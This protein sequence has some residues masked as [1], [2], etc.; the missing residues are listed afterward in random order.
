MCRM[1]FQKVWIN[2]I[3]LRTD[4]IGHLIHWK[5]DEIPCFCSCCI[6]RM[7]WGLYIC[8]YLCYDYHHDLF[9][10]E[11]PRNELIRMKIKGNFTSCRYRGSL[12]EISGSG[13]QNR[14]FHL[15]LQW[16]YCRCLTLVLETENSSCSSESLLFCDI[17]YIVGWP[18]PHW[19]LKERFFVKLRRMELF[20][21]VVVCCIKVV[22]CPTVWPSSFYLILSSWSESRWCK[23]SSWK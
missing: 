13:F 18:Q 9:S 10:L 11:A 14:K 12:I 6:S 4:Y 20:L 23:W 17:S 5:T 8:T 21:Y 22:G 19:I 7:V 15:P 2:M 3:L 16:K 1:M